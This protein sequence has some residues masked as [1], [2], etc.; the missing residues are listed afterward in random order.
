MFGKMFK[1]V[2][3]QGCGLVLPFLAHPVFC[4]SA[5]VELTKAMVDG[6]SDSDGNDFLQLQQ[7]LAF[8]KASSLKSDEAPPL[9]KHCDSTVESKPFAKDIDVPCDVKPRPLLHKAKPKV[10]QRVSLASA[11]ASHGRSFIAMLLVLW[12]KFQAIKGGESLEVRN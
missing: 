12:Q 2:C 6:D 11:A 3:G 4:D 1:C 5:A 9:K 10:K 8:D 7:K